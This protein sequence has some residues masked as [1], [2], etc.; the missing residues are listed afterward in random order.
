MGLD[1][2]GVSRSAVRVRVMPDFWFILVTCEVRVDNVLIRDVSTRFF[3]EFGAK[4]VL[5]EWTWRQA[6]YDALRERGLISAESP[7]ISQSNVG[8][9]LLGPD[10]VRRQIRHN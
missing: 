9:A 10:D 3:H 2:N 4:H 6:S 7:H 1:D 5:R 8:T